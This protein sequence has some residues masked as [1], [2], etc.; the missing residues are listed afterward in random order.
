V[1]VSTKATAER[2]EVERSL[3]AV[4]DLKMH[5]E[6]SVQRLLCKEISDHFAKP[7]WYNKN[8]LVVHRPFIL[9][10]LKRVKE[11]AIQGVKSIRHYFEKKYDIGLLKVAGLY[12]HTVA[13]CCAG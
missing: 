2:K 3:T 11:K 4:Y 8:W 12:W 13:S 5:L 6:P 7:L 9:A 1:D 10:C